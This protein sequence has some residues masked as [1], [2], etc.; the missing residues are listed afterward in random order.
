MH[1]HSFTQQFTDFAEEHDTRMAFHA[2]FFVLTFFAAVFLNVGAF[3]MLVLAHA[4]LDIVKYRLCHRWSWTSTM[5][6]ALRESLFDTFLITF[7]LL[8]GVYLHHGSSVILLSSMVR[9]E[10]LI[11]RALG[12]TLAE[13]HVLCHVLTQ[14]ANI[15]DHLVHAPR[16]LGNARLTRQEKFLMAS[17]VG[18]VVLI[19]AA[20]MLI[21]IPHEEYSKVMWENL[22]IF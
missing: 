11:V 13:M 10:W 12:M 5:K 16:A 17:T 7:S 2:W 20:P 8:L 19:A 9:G 15:R 22:S 3:V 14:F 18:F 4:S 6:G 1:T 21:G